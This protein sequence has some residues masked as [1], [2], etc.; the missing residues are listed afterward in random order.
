MKL[1][2]SSVL[3]GI[4]VLNFTA[5]GGGSSSSEVISTPSTETS[6][7][8]ETPSA[9]A[10][11]IRFGQGNSVDNKVTFASGNYTYNYNGTKVDISPSGFNV[12]KILN[13]TSNGI[14]SATGGTTYSYSR[15]GAV[16][17]STDLT[18]ADFYYVGTKTAS[19]PTTG[20][21]TYS[22]QI[23]DSTL[24]NSDA[25]FNVNYGDKTINSSSLALS[26]TISGSN[27]SGTVTGGTFNGAFFGPNAE[28]L[29]GIGTTN[30]SNF[31]FGAKK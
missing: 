21:A 22:G 26:G 20:T 24:A 29:G 18:K 4:A 31:S 1:F 14:K 30:N 23:V 7:G 16:S 11:G 19:M 9:T 17:S 5:C 27:F 15:F 3:A 8:T 28:E 6:N 10:S 12:N 13:L 2:Y 25:T